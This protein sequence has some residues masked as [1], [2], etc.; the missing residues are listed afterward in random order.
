MTDALLPCPF[1]GGANLKYQMDN[2][3]GWIAHVKCKDC[4]DMLGPM[5][6]FKYD[7]K[8]D[9]QSDAANMWNTRTDISQARTAE[10]E[11]ARDLGIIEGDVVAQLL[12]VVQQAQ[13]EGLEASL[14]W[15]AA[16][17][18]DCR[19]LGRDGDVARGK[20]DR[21]GGSKARA[22]LKAKP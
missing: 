19:K 13:I 18:A 10:L 11:E 4:D 12:V 5:S 9:A 14:E 3:D 22:A 21:D 20:L 8:P 15:Y 1:C 17:V 6:E 2:I 16:H 7:S